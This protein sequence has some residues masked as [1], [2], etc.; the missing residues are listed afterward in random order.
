MAND[1][2]VNGRARPEMAL[3][4]GWVLSTNIITVVFRNDAVSINKIPANA[5]RQL[6]NRFRV[7]LLG[8]RIEVLS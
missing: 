7:S 4:I 1:S 2:V 8:D 3:R 6:Q 5:L